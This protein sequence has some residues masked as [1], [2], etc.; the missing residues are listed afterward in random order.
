MLGAGYK[1]NVIP[2]EA[3]AHIDTRFLPGHEEELFA[4]IDAVLGDKV[5]REF[6]AHDIAVETTFDG[7]SIDLMAAALKAEDPHAV[8]VPYMLSGG[9]DAKSISRLGIRC[10]GFAPLL[11]PPTLDFGSLFHGVDERVP[12]DALK[13]G[14]RVLD[15]FLRAV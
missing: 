10:Y 6:V 5:S 12:V 15:R 4:A 13:F 3:T 7:P 8:A 14:T 1:V 11:L 2:G 9:T